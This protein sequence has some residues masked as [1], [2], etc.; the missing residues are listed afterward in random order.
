MDVSHGYVMLPPKL[1][2]KIV[3]VFSNRPEGQCININR[4]FGSI[5]TST[6]CESN[7]F[8]KGGNLLTWS[9]NRYLMQHKNLHW[10]FASKH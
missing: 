9:V 3:S 7:I 1:P 6:P 10:Q 8:D 5:S 4:L 2:N